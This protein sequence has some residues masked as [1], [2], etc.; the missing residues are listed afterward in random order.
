LRHQLERHLLATTANQQGDMRLLD[1]F[2]LVD[3]A[4]YLVVLAFKDRFF[5]CPHSQD[6]LNGIT[7][8]AQ[9]FSCV[10][11]LIAIGAIFVLKPA[12]SNTKVQASV[13]E[14]IDCAGHF[15]EQ[16]RITITVAGD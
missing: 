1:P 14:N 8:A 7:Q 12:C 13:A 16:S 3:R 10:R 2:G 4:T 5:L 11:I 9:T 15:G 6:Y